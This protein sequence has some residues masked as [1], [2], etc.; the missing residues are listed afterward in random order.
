MVFRFS[1]LGAHKR[2]G[3]VGTEQDFK[4]ERITT[5]HSYKKPKGLAHDIAIL[6]LHKPALLNRAVNLACLPE[7][8]GSV[9]DGKMCWVT[10]MSNNTMV[11]K[12]GGLITFPSRFGH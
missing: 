7:S 2:R 4:V 1:R 9:S 11:L 6:K 10:G 5:H 12:K 3:Q 8:S